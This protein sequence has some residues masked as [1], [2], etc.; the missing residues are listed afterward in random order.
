MRLFG[1][2]PSST[3]TEFPY[4]APY[5][6]SFRVTFS[7]RNTLRAPPHSLRSEIGWVRS[8]SGRKFSS[9]LDQCLLV[10]KVAQKT[11]ESMTEPTRLPIFTPQ[12]AVL[13]NQLRP[14]VCLFINRMRRGNERRI[15]PGLHNFNDN[16]FCG[17]CALWVPLCWVACA[18]LSA[19]LV[20][21]MRFDLINMVLMSKQ[22]FCCLSSALGLGFM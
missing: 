16:S 7:T 13:C 3:R 20:F 15:A 5:P 2:F 21:S 9:G 8:I 17:V 1:P 19:C 22:D 11:I 18:C 14:S 4:C 6:T 10:D 12:K